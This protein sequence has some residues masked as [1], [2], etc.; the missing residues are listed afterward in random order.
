MTH[1]GVTGQIT[2]NEQQTGSLFGAASKVQVQ[3]ERIKHSAAT[4]I[5]RIKGHSLDFQFPN[6]YAETS[7]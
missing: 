6:N 7:Y 3:A 5:A 4:S 1:V 2:G